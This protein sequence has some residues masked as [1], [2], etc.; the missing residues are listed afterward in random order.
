[1][2][3]SSFSRP[4]LSFSRNQ[5]MHP[6]R[7]EVNELVTGMHSLLD[8]MIGDEHELELE[9]GQP[10]AVHADRGQLSQVIMNLVVNARDA[11][12]HGGG[13]WIRT[14][15]HDQR[16]QGAG[17]VRAPRPGPHA[18]IEVIDEG[19]GMSQ[20]VA[21]HIFEPFFT[22]KDPGKG[23]GLGLSTVY[24]IVTQNGG[25]ISVDSA[26]GRGARFCVFL[27]ESP[28][29]ARPS[30]VAAL[31]APPAASIAPTVLLV[32]DEPQILQLLRRTLARAGFNVLIAADG[33]QALAIL[34]AGDVVDLMLTDMMLTDTNGSKLIAA[35]R[36]LRPGI[37][38]M[39][40]SGFAAGELEL[41]EGA[42]FIEKPFAPDALTARVR[43]VL[44][45]HP[46]PS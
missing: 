40:M 8:R 45:R 35:A 29:T 36:R 32:D 24:G 28:E 6:E 11:L 15:S 38:T 9:L 26:P 31:R 39:L 23:T 1:A 17:D 20:E 14:A 7:I 22:T 46:E 12:P 34:E 19:H 16:A 27:P 25:S 18:V 2:R 21:E 41:P 30:A 33:A 13:I 44:G 43:E 42:T 37:P 5:L 3:A 10:P 4:L